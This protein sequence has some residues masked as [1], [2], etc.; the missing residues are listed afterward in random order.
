MRLGCIVN[1]HE[2]VGCK[3]VHCGRIDLNGKHHMDGCRCKICEQEYHDWKVQERYFK[4]RPNC[5][6]N[7]TLS[8]VGC[9]ECGDFG[10][11]TQ[12]TVLRCAKCGREKIEEEM[13]EANS[14][15]GEYDLFI[16]P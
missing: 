12:V 9:N 16:Y 10:T 4:E 1:Q 2:Y 6:Y 8:C 14:F 15:F 11:R 13:Y 5:I 3:C 7:D